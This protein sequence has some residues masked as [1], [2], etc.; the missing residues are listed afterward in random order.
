MIDIYTDY[1]PKLDLHGEDRVN[2]IIKLDEFIKDNLILKQK[3][4]VVIHG[5]GTGILKKTVHD[6]LKKD[7]RIEDY[8]LS[9]NNGQTIISLKFDK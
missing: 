7:K 9:I 6:Y 3:N 8:K 2:A 4:I 5:I 1:L